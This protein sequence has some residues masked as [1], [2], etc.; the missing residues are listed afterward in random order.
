M[1]LSGLLAAEIARKREAAKAKGNQKRQKVSTI[2]DAKLQEKPKT[3]SE[4][5]PASEVEQLLNSVPQNK[6]EGT[7]KAFDGEDPKLSKEAQLRK[8]D[9]LV[10]TEKRN[11]AYKA[12]LDEELAVSPIVTLEDIASI[13]TQKRTLEMKVRRSLKGLLALW[14][15][16]P[17]TPPEQYTSGMLK[18]VKRDIVKLLYKLRAEKLDSDIVLSLATIIYYIQLQDF[19]K[20]NESYMKLSI[21][22]VAYPIGIRDVGIHARSAL[23]KIRGEDKSTIANVMKSESTRKWIL[24]VKRLISYCETLKKANIE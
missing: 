11:D 8:L 19:V 16:K 2:E 24:A 3:E 9:L 20:A 4:A 6:L 14:E 13:D 15:S 5:K 18:E 10:K 21:G 23:L 17:Q 7:L 1:G 22:N 12:Y